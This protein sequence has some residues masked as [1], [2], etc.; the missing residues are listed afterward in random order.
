MGKFNYT[1]VTIKE[2]AHE[3]EIKKQE[4]AWKEEKEGL[5]LC[6]YVLISKIIKE[7]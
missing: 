1:C 7:K 4:R 5:E 6:N 3:F 2:K